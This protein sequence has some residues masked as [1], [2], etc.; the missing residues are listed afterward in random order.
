M[1]KKEIGDGLMALF[2]YPLPD[3]DDAERAARHR[4]RNRCELR[5]NCRDSGPKPS[6]KSHTRTQNWF[7]LDFAKVRPLHWP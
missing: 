6:P 4:H 7:R 1:A 2:G 5:E 3:K